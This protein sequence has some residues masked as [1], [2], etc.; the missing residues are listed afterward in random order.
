M[1]VFEMVFY[2]AIAGIIGETAVKLVRG[3][4]AKEKEIKRLRERVEE[5]DQKLSDTMTELVDTRA[6]LDDEMTMRSELAE[7]VDFAERLLA[8]GP[9]PGGAAPE[10]RGG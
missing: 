9:P 2:L 3:H 7:R 10:P 6:M 1:G 8:S 4:P 5:M